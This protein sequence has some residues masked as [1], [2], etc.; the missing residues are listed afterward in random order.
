M[1][2]VVVPALEKLRKELG[3][4]TSHGG[5]WHSGSRSVMEREWHGVDGMR[6]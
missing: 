5:L 6:G 1:F 4:E 3:R 2:Y